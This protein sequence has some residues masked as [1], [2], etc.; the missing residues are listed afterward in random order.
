MIP[1]GSRFTRGSYGFTRPQQY[2]EAC[3]TPTADAGQSVPMDADEA[4][5]SLDRFLSCSA[6][7]HSLHVAFQHLSIS[8]HRRIAIE[9]SPRNIPTKLTPKQGPSPEVNRI[10]VEAGGSSFTTDERFI[11]GIFSIAHGVHLRTY[12]LQN[13]AGL[14]GA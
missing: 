11:E 8:L 6:N 14:Q 5:R 3:C 9:R 1:L 2:N 12:P 7:F 13:R 10:S 4:L